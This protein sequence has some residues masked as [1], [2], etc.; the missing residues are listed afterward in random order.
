[1]KLTLPSR[2]HFG[3]SLKAVVLHLEGDV[4]CSA[5]IDDA[6]VTLS[7]LPLLKKLSL[8]LPAYLPE[9]SLSS[10]AFAPQL[11]EFSC[12]AAEDPD[13]DEDDEDADWHP[14]KLQLDQ[15][16]MMPQLRRMDSSLSRD[17][18]SYLLRAPHSL[19]WQEIPEV[20]DVDDEV[21]TSSAFP[22]LTKLVT[23]RCRTVAFLPM[24][25]SLRSLSLW[26]NSPA[27]L[28]AEIV[29]GLSYCSQLT[30][31]TLRNA[32]DVTAQHLSQA[33]PHLPELR[34]LSLM[35]CSSLASLS[36]LAECAGLSQSLQ[37]LMLT[38]CRS[39]ALRATELKHVM[40]LKSLAKL[41]LHSSFVEPLDVFSQ[42]FLT[43]PSA[44]LPSLVQFTYYSD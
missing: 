26:M 8:H 25:T 43:P 38:A 18:L 11:R 3:A 12:A 28:A 37:S 30:E 20:R 6:I 27:R 14:T 36:F 33:L 44:V 5:V 39:P 23:S 21:V 10:L 35:F 7:R 16:R 42:H 34:E 4:K 40:T 22:T 2:L 41:G 29:T 31:L 1:M 24:F 32:H 19:Q 17:D 15:L 13:E 9:L